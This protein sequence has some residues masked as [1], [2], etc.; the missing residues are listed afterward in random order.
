MSN[1]L[2]TTTELYKGI[3][4][5][6]IQSEIIK[7]SSS[8]EYEVINKIVKINKNNY[9]VLNLIYFTAYDD[10]FKINNLFKKLF[11][12]DICDKSKKLIKK[13]LLN[14]IKKGDIV[15]SNNFSEK[16]EVISR[17]Y[18]NQ[19][20]KV[21]ANYKNYFNILETDIIKLKLNSIFKIGDVVE[22][23]S[24]IQLTEKYYITN[25]I[26]DLLILNNDT[27]DYCSNFKLVEDELFKSYSSKNIKLSVGDEILYN[28]KYYTISIIEINRVD[29]TIYYYVKDQN[30]IE[31]HFRLVSNQF[32]YKIKPIEF[33]FEEIKIQLINDANIYTIEEEYYDNNSSSYKIRSS[34]NEIKYLD[35]LKDI[36]LYKKLDSCYK[37]RIGMA[38]VFKDDVFTIQSIEFCD[39]Y[40]NLKLSNSFGSLI[41][42]ANLDNNL[43]LVDESYIFNPNFTDYKVGNRF[44]LLHGEPKIDKIGY[45]IDGIYLKQSR[46][47]MKYYI[48]N[49]KNGTY[50]G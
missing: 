30:D 25:I 19:S 39:K 33:Q 18:K 29:K 11:M 49:I 50:N 46:S 31:L 34:N 9:D 36:I 7:F 28:E 13:T 12:M 42:D 45:D 35:S 22:H 44:K 4:S 6:Q 16:F 38:C 1:K 40:I 3:K 47:T 43:I 15:L 10:I 5:R 17:D 23:I 27:I 41:C 32:K 8:L 37:L 21:A 26:G 14:Y 48:N 24:G 20:F 2:L